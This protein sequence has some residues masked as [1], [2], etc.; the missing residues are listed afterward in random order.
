MSSRGRLVVYPPS[1]NWITYSAEV[2]TPSRSVSTETP[3]HGV[4]SFDHFVTQWISAVTSSLC[5]ARNS[6]HVHRRG[7]SISPTIEKSHWS[8][9]VW[10]VGPAERTGKSYVRYWPGGVRSAGP[11]LRRPRKPL[12]ITGGISPPSSLG[13]GEVRTPDQ[14]SPRDGATRRNGQP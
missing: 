5:S 8:I 1:E 14:C 9:G 13:H 3:F 7:S 4:S 10:G 12:E 6:S 2:S 11:S